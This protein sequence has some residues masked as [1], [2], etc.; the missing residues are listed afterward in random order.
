LFD[1]S[2]PAASYK[3]LVYG[4]GFFFV[5][6]FSPEGIAGLFKWLRRLGR[7]RFMSMDGKS[8]LLTA[9]EIVKTTR[10]DK[11]FPRTAYLAVRG[12]SKR[13][14]GLSAVQSVDLEVCR[15]EIVA[16]IGPN[17]AGK[18][19]LFNLING[20]EYP[21]AGSILLGGRDLQTM[22]I[23]DRAISIGRS[24]QVP[25]L[26]PD[27]TVLQ[28]VAARI[29][30][31]PERRSESE[32]LALARHQLADFS[33]SEWS[34]RLVRDVGLGYHKLIDLARASAGEPPLLL[35]DEPAVG[36]T[37]AEL[38]HLSRMLVF[39]KDQGAAVLIV[40]HNIGFVT[41]IADRVVVIE[42]GKLI[43]V[44]SVADVIANPAV[45]DAYFGALQ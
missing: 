24:F 25:R 13:F 18:S 21:T 28:N 14:G 39:L 6:L 5:V 40:E 43:A 17:G 37:E 22:S 26:V 19:T 11:T 16:L 38:N 9:A 31:L 27:M 23:H 32:R 20:I 30:N 12:A 10:R 29:D 1:V 42:S 4:L 33:L 3:L 41:K 35:L 15:G 36:L 2:G 34:D 45:Q 7:L 44:G 8:Q